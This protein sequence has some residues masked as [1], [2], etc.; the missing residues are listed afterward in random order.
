MRNLIAL[1]FV[2]MLGFGCGHDDASEPSLTTIAML[3]SRDPELFKKTVILYESDDYLISTYFDKYISSYPF[4]VLWGYEEL[5][6]QAIQDTLTL[7][8]LYMEDYIKLNS[9]AAYILAYHLGN[10]SC[11]IYDKESQQVIETIKMEAYSMGGPMTTTAGR[12]FYIKARI[13]FLETV[14]VMS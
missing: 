1:L 2:M 12:R 13:L 6:Q 11:L 4:D 3:E 9:D 10:G 7:D 8:T 14:D 5:K